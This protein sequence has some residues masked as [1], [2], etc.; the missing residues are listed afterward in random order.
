MDVHR[1]CEANLRSLM[2]GDAVDKRRQVMDAWADHC[3][4]LW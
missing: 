2:G 4:P 1:V 3:R